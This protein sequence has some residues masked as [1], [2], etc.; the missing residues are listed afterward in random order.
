VTAMLRRH[1]GID[2]SGTKT[3]TLTRHRARM[4][5]LMRRIPCKY[6]YLPNLRDVAV[7]NL[8]LLQKAEVLSAE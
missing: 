8:Y 3:P 4:Q 7:Q 1:I 2:Y 6:G 5:V